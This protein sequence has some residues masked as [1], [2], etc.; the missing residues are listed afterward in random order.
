VQ[1]AQG[2]S[3]FEPFSKDIYNWCKNHNAQTHIVHTS[4]ILACRNT[5]AMP[6]PLTSH[7]SGPLWLLQLLPI[8]GAL[9]VLW[10]LQ[11]L[12]LQ[13][14]RWRLL[15][16]LLLLLREATRLLLLLLVLLPLCLR[17]LL[18]LLLLLQLHCLIEPLGRVWGL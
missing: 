3:V 6:I 9:A 18:L 13:R 16:L 1:D 17:L 11:L 12:L 2:T 5:Q 15:L 4:C 10:L 14:W 7:C 8:A